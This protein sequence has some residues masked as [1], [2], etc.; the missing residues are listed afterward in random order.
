MI[1]ARVPAVKLMQ[2][3]APVKLLSYHAALCVAPLYDMEYH[4]IML[5]NE[6]TGD[7]Q[8]THESCYFGWSWDWLHFTI[9][10]RSEGQV[11]LEEADSAFLLGLTLKLSAS[12]YVMI[13]GTNTYFCACPKPGPGLP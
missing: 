6:L 4:P 7:L 5:E 12:H 9:M 13:C 3:K 8:E 10:I 2:E 11:D 1:I